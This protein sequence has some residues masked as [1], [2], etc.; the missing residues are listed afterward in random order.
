MTERAIDS[1]R[2]AGLSYEAAVSETAAEIK[3]ILKGAPAVIRGMTKHLSKAAGKLIR[4]RALL[5]CA[6]RE[7]DTVSPDAVKAAA[8]AELLH[9]ATLVHDDIIDDADKRRGI[10]TVHRKFGEKYAVLCGDYLFCTALELVSS[11]GVPGERETAFGRA[12]PHYLT[13]VC[14][15]ELLQ[16][17]NDF[18]FELTERAY[19]EIIRGKTAALFEACFYMGFL[20]SDE[21]GEASA[22]YTEAGNTLGVIFQLSDDCADYASTLRK[23]KKPVLSDYARGVVTLPLIY[24]MK[25]DAALAARAKKGMEL[26][27]LKAAVLAAGGLDYAYKKI[28]GLYKKAS[29]AIQAMAGARKRELLTELLKSSAGKM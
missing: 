28:D 20:L 5:A 23:S 29:K 9:L 4:A 11:A 16:N 6:L 26:S 17:R 15:G 18:N 19:F 13:E 3:G 2:V 7:D 10:E 25:R 14:L 24:A 27:E 22:L 21:K 8:A 1:P 12:F